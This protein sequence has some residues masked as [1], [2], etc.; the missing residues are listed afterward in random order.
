MGYRGRIN[1]AFKNAPVITADENSRFVLFSDCHRGNGTHNDNFLKT[2]HL[3]FAA[4]K[5]YYDNGFTYIELGDGDELW[6]NRSMEQIK[7]IHSNVFWL[8]SLFY[9]ENRLYMLYGNHD[10]E[11][12]FN[13]FSRKN[14]STYF[15]TSS[16]SFTGLCPDIKF[17]PGIILKDICTGASLYITHGHQ[18]SLLN[19][20]LWRLG[21]FLVRYVW[22]PLE[23]IGILD[24][25]NAAKNYTVKKRSEHKL[26]TWAEENN[27][28]LITGHTHRPML[29]QAPSLYI[30]TGSCVHPRCITCIEAENGELKLVKWFMGTRSNGNFYLEREVLS[31][32]ALNC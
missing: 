8:L 6:E 28:I 22:K 9:R 19:S 25:T 18:S 11:K 14:F 30:N 24:P 2:Q 32:R 7:E 20:T 10:M 21:R 27:K 23:Q 5:H 16:Q 29:N 4:L 13:S 3:Y 15:C 12:K 1:R 31:T 26:N 17:Y